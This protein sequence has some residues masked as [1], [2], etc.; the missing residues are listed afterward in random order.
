MFF[1]TP[2][3]FEQAYETSRDFI[4]FSMDSFGSNLRFKE[5]MTKG[6]TSLFYQSE[7]AEKKKIIL[8]DGIK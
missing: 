3:S 1:N 6:M 2:P 4:K 5:S 7:S 8:L